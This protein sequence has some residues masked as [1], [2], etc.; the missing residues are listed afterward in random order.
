[1]PSLPYIER[2]SH[3]ILFFVQLEHA[4]RTYEARHDGKPFA[5]MHCYTKLKRCPK[6]RQAR[7]R[8]ATKP[9]GTV[10]L[11]APMNTSAGR[12][13][14]TKRAKN[15]LSDAAASEKAAASIEKY[16]AGVSTTMATRAEKSEERWKTIFQK[17]D[18]KIVIDKEKVAVEKEIAA[19]KKRKEDMKILTADTSKYDAATLEAHNYFRDII[20][21]EIA[22]RRA[23]D[24]AAAQAL[25]AAAEAEEA[26]AEA[27]AAAA[28]AQAEADAA[29]AAAASAGGS[30]ATPTS[31][32]S[33]TAS[34]P[35]PPSGE[36]LPQQQNDDEEDVVEVDAL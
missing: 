23:A 12:P 14:G 6:W 11:D 10:D 3:C 13:I 9:D 25:A 35:T 32:P 5:F 1:M 21:Q 22:D 26:A 19:V 30:S 33:G 4:M 16:I 2:R 28:A 20:L 24:I 34:A 17:Q 29:A 7:V 15:A 36:Q 8:L 31:A 27:A 18:E